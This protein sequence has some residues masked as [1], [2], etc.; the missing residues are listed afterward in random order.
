M[1]KRYMA[2]RTGQALIAV[3]GEGRADA[4]GCRD[5]PRN[6]GRIQHQVAHHAQEEHDKHQSQGVR[7]KS[8]WLN[9]A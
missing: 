7:P 8:G 3:A 1:P 5:L 2:Q 6:R 9:H 4:D